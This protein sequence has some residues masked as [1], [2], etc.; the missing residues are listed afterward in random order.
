MEEQLECAYSTNGKRKQKCVRR[1]CWENYRKEIVGNLELS[2]WK[3][4]DGYKRNMTEI[5]GTDFI[6][7]IT[8]KSRLA[9]VDAVM[10]FQD[11]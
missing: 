11:T 1:F 6:W 4:L 9:F 8:R 5:F 10:K 2:R 3:H 7:L